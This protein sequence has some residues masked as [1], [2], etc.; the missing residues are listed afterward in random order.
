MLSLFL[1][2]NY[3]LL[4][5]RLHSSVHLL[6]VVVVVLFTLVRFVL[7]LLCCLLSVISFV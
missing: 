1:V 2:W 4:V 3:F 7:L 6:E 5:L